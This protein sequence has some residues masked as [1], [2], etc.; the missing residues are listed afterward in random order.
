MTEELKKDMEMYN[1]DSSKKKKPFT[2]NIRNGIFIGLF[3]VILVITIIYMFGGVEAFSVILDLSDKDSGNWVG[4]SNIYSINLYNT[5]SSNLTFLGTTT[6]KFGWYDPNLN[7]SIQYSFSAGSFGA[8]IRSVAVDN[9]HNIVYVGGQNGVSNHVN[10]SAFSI[11]NNATKF[12]NNTGIDYGGCYVSDIAVNRY[13]NVSYLGITGNCPPNQAKFAYYDA[14]QN[15][16]FNLTTKANGNWMFEGNAGEAGNIWTVEYTGNAM[17]RTYFGGESGGS[18]GIIPIFGYYDLKRDILI[19]INISNGFA[20]WGA[21]NLYSLSYDTKRNI[22]YMAGASGRFGFFN[23]TSNQTVNLNGTAVVN[24]IGG[25][26]INKIEVNQRNGLVFMALDDGKYGYYNP[27]TNQTIDLSSQDSNNFIGVN[28]L[29][30]IT[31][32]EANNKTYFA[33]DAGT[34]AVFSNFPELVSNSPPTFTSGYPQINSTDGTNSTIRNLTVVWKAN[35]ANANDILRYNLTVYRNNISNYTYRNVLTSIDALVIHT[36]NAVNNFT[37]SAGST[38]KAQVEVCDNSSNCVLSN[39][40]E[41]QLINSAPTVPLINFPINNLM[42]ANYSIL[43]LSC[44]GSIDNENDAIT[45]EYWVERLIS[46]P[47]INVGNGTIESYVFNQSIET[48]GAYY[49]RCRASDNNGQGTSGYNNTRTFLVDRRKI[50]ENIS[51]FTS[52]DLQGSSSLFRLNLSFNRTTTFD[53]NATFT[54][55][56][57]N[58]NVSKINEQDNRRLFEVSVTTPITGTLINFGWNFTIDQNNH[59]LILNNSFM[60]QQAL[61]PINL[62]SCITPLSSQAVAVN[63]TL[64]DEVNNSV[65]NGS[66]EGTFTIWTNSQSIN[67]TSH[68]NQI[69]NQNIRSVLLCISPASAILTSEAE[70]NYIIANREAKQYYFRNI[71]LNNLTQAIGLYSLD[72]NI[73]SP[74]NIQVVDSV[75]N[76]LTNHVIDI[77]LHN[78]G[79]NTLTTIAMGKSNFEGNHL[80]YLRANNPNAPYRFKIL[81]EIGRILFTSNTDTFITGDVVIRI[82]PSGSIIEL[83]EILNNVQKSLTFNPGTSTYSYSF[84]DTSGKVINSRLQITRRTPESD[85]ILVNQLLTGTSGSFSYTLPSNDTGTY[86]ATASVGF[87]GDNG[88]VIN[89][90]LATIQNEIID[91]ANKLYTI[92]GRQ[93]ILASVFVIGTFAM[94]GITSSVLVVIFSLIA[95]FFVWIMGFINLSTLAIT[96]MILVGGGI[97]FYKLKT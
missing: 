44:N 38:Y 47:T 2:I 15:A 50:I 16:I 1:D 79:N 90:P 89:L 76:A 6:G 34:F 30:A 8:D 59:T 9:Y 12:S 56:N 83:L 14:K 53:V 24:W 4:I 72:A 86:I 45:Y 25:T 78:V 23:E 84:T 58:Y 54:Y 5:S 68:L 29:R 69:D 52:P 32:D 20:W 17:N 19:K 97:L 92:I 65:M 64:R 85:T 26:N 57:T 40:S 70:I 39:T 82:A 80:I 31:I 96:L 49:W 42:T 73:D 3:I 60:G 74:I 81:D 51:T 71:T 63:F 66:F 87:V 37:A 28:A 10:F 41:L 94:L 88:A 93:G 21:N 48:E 22:T 43:N 27:S 61:T 75:G 46:P 18:A 33:G 35:D 77:Q 13:L 11:T 36:I 67:V 7:A 55:N 62:T 91:T 95:L